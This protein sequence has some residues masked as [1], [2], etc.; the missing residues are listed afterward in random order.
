[1]TRSN[2]GFRRPAGSELKVTALGGEASKTR[3]PD[4]VG[5]YS[6]SIP[7]FSGI[8]TKFGLCLP[9]FSVQRVA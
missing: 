2:S 7:V 3:N 1:M 9:K 6:V 5:G 4:H 8:E